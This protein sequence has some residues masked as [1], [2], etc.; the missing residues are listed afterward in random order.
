MRLR[1]HKKA[2]LRILA[3]YPVPF[4]NNQAEQEP[5]MKISGCFGSEGEARDF[6]TFRSVLSTARKK[7][8][9]RIA[10]LHKT[11]E[12]LLAELRI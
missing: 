3:E 10:A 4:T 1:C 2:V 8:W 6:A 12:E 9:N 11:P 7:D 5:R